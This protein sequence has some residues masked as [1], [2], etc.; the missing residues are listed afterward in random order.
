MNWVDLILN[1][2]G[3][4]LW[5]NWRAGKADLLGKRTPATLI[6]T[7]RSAAP[8]PMRRWDVPVVL[9][10]LIFLRAVLYWLIGPALRWSGILD[11][12]LISLSL[13]SDRFGRILLFSVLSFVLVLGI[14]YSWL[15]VLSLLRG[16]KPVH[17]FVRMQL[18]R[19]DGWAAGVKWILPFFVTA[20]F[21]WLVSWALA[22]LQIIPQPSQAW[23]IEESLLIATQGYLIWKFPVALLLVLYL[24]SSYVYF[25]RHPLWN[26][27]D[28]TAQTLLRPLKGVPFLR[29][30]K[31]DF[32]PVVGIALVFLIAQLAGWGIGML[33]KRLSY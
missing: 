32:T 7:L 16:P 6:G 15:L 1:I 13:R 19:I 12:G 10:A 4:L 20:I 23:R 14:F 21:W 29:I 26:Y 17:D 30:G 2:A 3:L 22:W 24:L 27:V 8:Q 33:Y 5:M 25:G 18:G 31:V 9:T 28:A 11:L